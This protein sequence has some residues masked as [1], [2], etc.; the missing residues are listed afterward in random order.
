MENSLSDPKQD[1]IGYAI[2]SIKLTRSFWSKQSHE[3]SYNVK[4][5]Y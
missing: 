2:S 1:Q 5:F 3:H 4:L